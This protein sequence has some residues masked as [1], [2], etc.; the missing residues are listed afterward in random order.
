M[1]KTWLRWTGVDLEQALDQRAYVG[2]WLPE[3]LL[4]APDVAGARRADRE[5][6]VS[7]RGAADRAPRPPTRR[8]PA[9]ADSDFRE[10]R[11]GRDASR[12]RR[13]RGGP[14]PT[15]RRRQNGDLGCQDHYGIGARQWPPDFASQPSTTCAIP[16]KLTRV[17]ATTPI[18]R[19][20]SA[21]PNAP[22]VASPR[23]P[24]R[25][26]ALIVKPD[27]P[28]LSVYRGLAGHLGV[29]LGS[30]RSARRCFVHR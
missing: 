30:V 1:Q 7:D 17:I 15:R 6:Q 20:S 2:P 16:R 11:A 24:D 8:P 18:A 22:S 21:T 19:R 25:R 23:R 10:D 9:S 3:P 26:S 28:L 27:I 5:R 4:A 29:R 14:V 12:R 13:R